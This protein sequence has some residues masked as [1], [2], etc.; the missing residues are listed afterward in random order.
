[1]RLA[2]EPIQIL[3]PS[4]VV[5]NQVNKI[6]ITLGILYCSIAIAIT[7][8]NPNRACIQISNILKITLDWKVNINLV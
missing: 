7:A 4:I 1:M 3:S 6:N 2:T 5:S 8:N